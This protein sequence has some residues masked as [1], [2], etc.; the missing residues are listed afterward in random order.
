VSGIVGSVHDLMTTKR[1]PPDSLMQCDRVVCVGTAVAA[2]LD[3]S[4]F[5]FA[6]N[7]GADVATVASGSDPSFYL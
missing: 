5:V 7:A 6:A 3:I 1:A 2:P 4:G